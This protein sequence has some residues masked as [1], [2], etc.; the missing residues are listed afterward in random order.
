MTL[1]FGLLDSVLMLSASCQA[2]TI[3]NVACM[4]DEAFN[5]NVA[6]L[7]SWDW[8]CLISILTGSGG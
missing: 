3:S 2:A 6:L 4:S 8:G 5:S 7:M 1:V